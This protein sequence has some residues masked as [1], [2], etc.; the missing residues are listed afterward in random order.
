MLCNCPQFSASLA[1]ISLTYSGIPEIN[2]WVF[3][4]YCILSRKVHPTSPSCHRLQLQVEEGRFR[5]GIRKHFFSKRV[6]MHWHSCPG[7]GGVT[8]PGGAQELWRCGT[9]G[10][11]HTW[12]GL[13]LVMG[14]VGW[15]GAGLGDLSGLFPTSMI[16]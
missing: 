12:D 5:L 7:S 1:Q 10:C 8:I 2:G 15:A 14:T 4:E 16:Q 3:T 6:V 13:I 9:E 11:G